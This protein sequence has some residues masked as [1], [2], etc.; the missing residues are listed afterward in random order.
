MNVLRLNYMYNQKL[1]HI[2][3]Y[4][5]TTCRKMLSKSF[6]TW[7]LKKLWSATYIFFNINR[8]L[9]ATNMEIKVKENID[10][11]ENISKSIETLPII[12]SF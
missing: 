4:K 5:E 6:E 10:K 9:V 8:V 12:Q 1:I 7:F 11:Q 3:K 2:Y